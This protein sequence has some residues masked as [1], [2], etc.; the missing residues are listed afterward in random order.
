LEEAAS[1]QRIGSGYSNLSSSTSWEQSRLHLTKRKWPWRTERA[2]QATYLR[3]CIPSRRWQRPRRRST[4]R[5]VPYAV[6]GPDIARTSS[7]GTR[8][9][10]RRTCA[11]T[12]GIARPPCDPN[13]PRIL[14][15]ENNSGRYCMRTRREDRDLT[16]PHPSRRGRG[17]ERGGWIGRMNKFEEAWI[18]NCEWRMRRCAPYCCP[19]F[20]SGEDV[21]TANQT[22]LHPRCTRVA[23]SHVSARTEKCLPLA[24]RAHEALVDRRGWSGGLD[25]VSEK[26]KQRALWLDEERLTIFMHECSVPGTC[27]RYDIPRVLLHVSIFLRTLLESL[28]E[29]VRA[30]ERARKRARERE[31]EREREGGRG[32]CLSALLADTDDSLSLWQLVRVLQRFGS[33]Q[34]SSGVWPFL[35]FSSKSAPCAAK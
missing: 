6:S 31:R 21:L 14:R 12:D 23:A 26:E 35:F 19:Y 1:M 11:R 9:S 30:R 3:R 5:M 4:R 8:S 13:T 22:F 29:K 18:S 10:R 24:V 17:S 34:R 28:H 32:G 20:H 27:T 15:P 2:R 7:S 25:I 16:F 33:G